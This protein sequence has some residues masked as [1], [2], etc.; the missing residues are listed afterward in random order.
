MGS[1]LVH[2]AERRAWQTQKADEGLRRSNIAWHG[3]RGMRWHQ[4]LPKVKSLLQSEAPPSWICIHLG[5]NN[6]ASIPLRALTAMALQDLK[7]LSKIAPH[8]MFI[9]SEILPRV[10][11]R[12]ANSDAKMEKT[13]KTLNAAIKKGILNLN[14]QCIKHPGI[15]WD[16]PSLFRHDGVHLSN[17]GNDIFLDN[18]KSIL[19]NSNWA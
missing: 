16:I 9:W 14:G 7:T 1:S 19:A 18:M 17:K 12:G 4:L 10:H 11:Y 5:G 6:L 3:Q 13:R 2:W 15:Q 8:T